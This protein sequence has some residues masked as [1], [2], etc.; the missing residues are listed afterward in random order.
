[1]SNTID[2]PGPLAGFRVLEWCQG[3]AGPTATFMLAEMGAEVITIERPGAM[4][5]GAELLGGDPQATR[6]RQRQVAQKVGGLDNYEST[7]HDKKSISINM[8][9]EAATEIIHHLIP[10]CDVFHTQIRTAAL[11]RHKLD[12]E[13]V[14]RLNPK[15][16]YSRISGQGPKGPLSQM[17]TSDFIMQGYSSMMNAMGDAATPLPTGPFVGVIDHMTGTL[18]CNGIVTALLARERTGQGQEVITSIL[19]TALWTMYGNLYSAIN[20]GLDE[21]RRHDRE[22]PG[23][24]MRNYYK[25]KDDKWIIVGHIGARWEQFAKVFGM[26]Y[27]LKDE[28]FSDARKLHVNHRESRKLFDAHFLKKTR[29][30][31]VDIG[32]KGDILCAPINTLTEMLT[33]EQVLAN[34]Y[35]YKVRDDEGVEVGYPG[36][37]AAFSKTPMRVKHH[38]VPVGT[39][40]AEILRDLAGYTDAEIQ[41]FREDEVTELSF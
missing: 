10:K 33:N 16:I 37:A 21:G 30:E 1:M 34:D 19:G 22:A 28:R 2:K 40:T 17:P 35:M 38:P 23:N 11:E 27:M 25:C 31:W 8:S 32:R 3:L 12:Y 15:I 20:R 39:H 29:D 24:P 5:I 36:Y 18:A 26:D 41:K 13:T 4:R 7:A 9:K 14:S 6:A